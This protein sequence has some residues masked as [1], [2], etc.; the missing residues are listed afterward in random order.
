MIFSDINMYQDLLF[1]F[2]F[3]RS[4]KILYRKLHDV[5]RNLLKKYFIQH[6]ARFFF[7]ELM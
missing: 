7:H 5:N 4:V 6:S 3:Y 2:I 1:Y